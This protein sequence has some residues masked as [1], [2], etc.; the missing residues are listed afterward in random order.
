MSNRN[1]S[2]VISRN[3]LEAAEIYRLAEEQGFHCLD[4]ELPWG[5]RLTRENANFDFGV[6]Q[7]TVVLVELPSPEVEEWLR[8]ERRTVQIIDHHLYVDFQG[9]RLDRRRPKSSLEQFADLYGFGLDEEQRL[10]AAN[11]RGSWP[12]MLATFDDAPE[13][14]RAQKQDEIW[15]QRLGR[16]RA[17]RHRD[18]A[19][20]FGGDAQLTSQ[21]L[22]A[23]VEWLEMAE[24]DG[25]LRVIGCGRGDPSDPELI[26]A[27]APH[28]F[29]SI[30]I[31]AIYLAHYLHPDGGA[32]GSRRW[33]NPG[34]QPGGPLEI[35]ILFESQP[36]D[37]ATVPLEQSAM[38][39]TQ[40]EYSAPAGTRG[41]LL[42]ELVDELAKSTRL[43][44]WAGGGNHSCFFG[45]DAGAA[46]PGELAALGDQLLNAVLAG[47]RPL[48][49]WRSQFMQV[50]RYDTEA[51]VPEIRPDTKTQYAD[52]A[53]GEPVR[54]YVVDYLRPFLTPR[55]EQAKDGPG[56][57]RCMR[58]V[59][60]PGQL[61]PWSLTIHSYRFRDDAILPR[62]RIAWPNGLADE[63][64][65]AH[66]AV[67]FLF[68]GLIVL[69]WAFQDGW[70][71]HDAA[72]EAGKGM[73]VDHLLHL[74][75]LE[76]AGDGKVR[77]LDSKPSVGRT[78]HPPS[79]ADDVEYPTLAFET[80][81]VSGI[82]SVARLLDF[83]ESARQCYSSY[84]SPSQQ[85]KLSL[86]LPSADEPGGW[87]PSP[88]SPL[89][90][91][92]QTQEAARQ[93]AS[94]FGDLVD[95]ALD[96]SFGL[97]RA[98]LTLVLDERA[99]VV[100]AA[101]CVG[102][103]PY[104]PAALDAQEVLFAR[105]STVEPFEP[106]HFYDRA[107]AQAEL[108][109]ARYDRFRSQEAYPDSSQLY[110]ATDH[111]LAFLG[112]GWFATSVAIKHVACQ[113]HRLFLIGLFYVSVFHS[114]S[115]LLA[116]LSRQR[117]T[118]D[119]RLRTLDEQ[120]S[121]A[122]RK[123]RPACDERAERLARWHDLD[124]LAAGVQRVRA[125]FII[126]AN[127]LWFDDVATQIQGR[128]LFE[129]ITRQLRVDEPYREFNTEVERTDALE[130]ADAAQ[131]S[132]QR[133][134]EITVLATFV[135]TLAAAGTIFGPVLGEGG[136][137]SHGLPAALVAALAP[138]LVLRMTRNLTWHQATAEYLGLLDEACPVVRGLW[139][140]LRPTRSAPPE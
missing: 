16:V 14:K 81:H 111:S 76:R 69:E 106:V 52:G 107:F 57:E 92:Q 80:E 134:K 113:Y 72:Q 23:A 13:Q 43:R 54:N 6:L 11:D 132:D 114:F 60:R 56:D 73:L 126:F 46:S 15:R 90:F 101:A 42:D 97:K 32:G 27:K 68:G 117:L 17:I 88:N 128:E 108:G 44:L 62:F 120:I 79:H 39:V 9:Q 31:D 99:R 94:W 130:R 135:G 83:N 104:L 112:H 19:F 8:I 59:E 129:I 109:R 30:L 105:L 102:A 48:V 65:M 140:R 121:T 77:E 96:K 34:A 71:E 3:D 87:A 45:A 36:E 127:G 137:G 119:A 136:L 41:R 93:P 131:R 53:V 116:E 75:R 49:R 110:A 133:A 86:I 91:G 25:R 100:T 37:P 51:V 61:D 85:K 21:Q 84:Y 124:E 118:I 74:P 58:S 55:S 123:G 47:N 4:V 78:T 82:D 103:R 70:P 66:L 138:V 29:R 67:H 115:H 1:V 7:D 28:A 12:A 63:R 20:R 26:L 22:D 95:Y 10:I 122:A 33:R 40:I 24:S 125:R 38:R 64:P 35:L 50:L 98:A 139:H 18:L 89:A 2:L 5:A